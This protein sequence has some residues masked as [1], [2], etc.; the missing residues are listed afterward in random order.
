MRGSCVDKARSDLDSEMSSA[1]MDL[2][3]T[4][5]R[6]IWMARVIHRQLRTYV[7]LVN[8]HPGL[9]TACSAAAGEGLVER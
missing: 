3:N 8:T 2:P 9:L 7:L 5:P 6:D 1:V 4:R